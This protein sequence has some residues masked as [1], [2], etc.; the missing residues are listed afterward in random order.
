MAPSSG[1]LLVPKAMKAIKFAV[2]KTA[3][4]IRSKLPQSNAAV[5]QPIPIRTTRQPIHPVAFLRQSRSQAQTRWFSTTIRNLASKPAWRN[6]G[7]PTRSSLPTSTISKTI[8]R[9]GGAPFASALRPNLTGGALPR[10]AGGY[11]L[12][13]V[14]KGGLRHFS[15]TPASQA[16]V[17][18]NVSAAVRTFWLGGQKAR[19]DGVDQKTGEK[20]WKA[21]T[22]VQDKAT[23]TM[24]K[25]FASKATK[26]TRLEFTLS[27]TVTALGA[28]STTSSGGVLEPSL[29]AEGLLDTLSIDFAHALQDL[30]AILSDLKRLYTLGDLP[31]SLSN[32]IL[33]VHFPGCDFQTVSS[34]CDE[35]AI[36]RGVI[37][38][39]E[40]WREDGDAEMALLFPFAD[41]AASSETDN[42]T[43]Y[44]ENVLPSQKREDVDWKNMLSPS[45]QS[46]HDSGAGLS[47]RSITSEESYSHL[48]SSL[49]PIGSNPWVE[50]EE[51]GEEGEEGMEDYGSDE[52]DASFS[53][54][55]KLTSGRF[56][57]R[58]SKE[59]EGVEGIYRFLAE[60]D[61]ARR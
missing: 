50:E 37:R 58:T 39:D 4:L 40:A 18:H 25:A 7:R 21:V 16:Q 13:G 38:E 26:G 43:R 32:S 54:S 28:F 14:G 17:V 60:C 51:D 29:N 41:S 22:E 3:S 45:E 61:G 53:A 15:H 35:L 57:R 52:L 11:T 48:E 36:R 19:Y 5:L 6:L 10:S 20:R 56:Q 1:H 47:T 55:D 49:P 34:L 27:P 24:S 59:Y 42:E 9:Q 44:F 31:L 23:K 46:S 12:G 2:S 30:A 8:V 33:R